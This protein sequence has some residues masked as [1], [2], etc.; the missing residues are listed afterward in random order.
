[1]STISR[2]AIQQR[3]SDA[4]PQAGQRWRHYKGAIYTI[5]CRSVDE[6]SFD[7]L[8]TYG[9]D[10]ANYTRTLKNFTE[11]VVADGVSKYRFDRVS[12]LGES[13]ST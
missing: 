4:G 9:Q 8:V 2:E 5:V 13:D 1:V 12:D 10:G 3:C 11:R 7:R 6:A